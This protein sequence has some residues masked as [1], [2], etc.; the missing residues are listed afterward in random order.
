MDPD[1][2][3]IKPDRAR[4]ELERQIFGGRPKVRALL[5]ARGGIRSS[6]GARRP[7]RERAK[8]RRRVKKAFGL[9]R[10]EIGAIEAG[11]APGPEGYHL[12]VSKAI[13]A[14]RRV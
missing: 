8:A 12:A 3:P 1:R 7:K 14:I 5:G 4:K 6:K 9:G 2:K 13:E 11:H 10:R